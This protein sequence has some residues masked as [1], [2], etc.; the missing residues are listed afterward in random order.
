[1]MGQQHKIVGT[2]WGIAGSFV[3]NSMG[4]G[5]LSYL[6]I[7]AAMISCWW[8]DMD[9]NSTKLGRKRKAVTTVASNVSKFL[10]LGAVALLAVVIVVSALQIKDFGIDTEKASFVL[11]GL[12]V[13][14]V[15]QNM[16]KKTELFKWATKHRGLMH[17]LVCPALM[18]WMST[19]IGAPIVKVILYGFIIG[20]CSHLFADMLTVEGCPILFPLSRSN[21]HILS[22]R[23]SSDACKTL[24]WVVSGLSII[25]GLYIARM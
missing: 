2:A 10:I 11:L 15:L 20:Y 5:M 1:M 19:A 16:L 9:H 4:F 13:F 7:P 25:L 8:P 21:V 6:T 3:M 12:V 22:F 24:A 17:T 14:M 23:A 18:Y